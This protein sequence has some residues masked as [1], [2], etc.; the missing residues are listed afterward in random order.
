MHAGRKGLLVIR[1]AEWLLCG[2]GALRAQSEFPARQGVNLSTSN[3]V[4]RS[5]Q[6]TDVSGPWQLQALRLMMC[7]SARVRLRGRVAAKRLVPGG[8]PGGPHVP[9]GAT[10]QAAGLLGGDTR[11]GGG[12]PQQPQH[13]RQS[14]VR[15]VVHLPTELRAAEPSTQLPKLAGLQSVCCS[16]FH[17]FNC[18]RGVRTA[19]SGASQASA[20][21]ADTR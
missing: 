9:Q 15:P 13:L 20:L 10:L 4:H 12:P 11:E 1:H 8:A 21:I 19:Q 14:A 2:C 16:R 17:H 18:T 7:C 5:K 6:M 3:L